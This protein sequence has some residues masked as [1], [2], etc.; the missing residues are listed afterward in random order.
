M[1]LE[2]V[3]LTLPVKRNGLDYHNYEKSSAKEFAFSLAINQKPNRA[4]K[5]M[6]IRTRCMR[7]VSLL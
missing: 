2:N 4:D 3:C 1:E 7:C 5:N 6:R